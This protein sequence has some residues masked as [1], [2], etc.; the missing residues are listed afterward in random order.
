[1]WIILIMSENFWIL[2]LSWLGKNHHVHL[3]D[4][5]VNQILP[6]FIAIL[7]QTFHSSWMN[8]LSSLRIYHS[9]LQPWPAFPWPIWQPWP[10]DFTWNP[11]CFL[12]TTWDKYEWRP[13][14]SGCQDDLIRQNATCMA[15]GDQ[16]ALCLQ[17]PISGIFLRWQQ[18]HKLCGHWN[19]NHRCHCHHHHHHHH[20]HLE[21]STS[22]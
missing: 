14:T 19:R 16:L 7:F 11:W 4:V 1:M 2:N 5:W 15:W 8:G 9:F 20:H 3:G 6:H 12:I 13:S 18:K 17:L 21:P 22:L 10:T